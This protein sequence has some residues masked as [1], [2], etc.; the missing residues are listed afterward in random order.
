MTLSFAGEI[1]RA[2]RCRLDEGE[3]ETLKTSG[4]TLNYKVASKKIVTIKVEMK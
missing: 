1:Y 3:E 2:V 4:C